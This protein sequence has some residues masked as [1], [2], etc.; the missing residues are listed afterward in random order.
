VPEKREIALP[1]AVLAPW[2]LAIG[3]GFELSAI[4]T[5]YPQAVDVPM[6]LIVTETGPRR[7]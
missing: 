3:V 6:D 7:R 1:D 2:P 5:I 4:E